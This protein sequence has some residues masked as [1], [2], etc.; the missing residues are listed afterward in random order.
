MDKKELM[1][2]LRSYIEEKILEGM[3]LLLSGW[4]C[5]VATADSLAAVDA[6]LSGAADAPNAIIADYH[7]GDGT[8]IEAIDRVRAAFGP[9]LPG[10]LVTADRSAEVR[11]LADAANIVV[12]NKPVRPASMRAWLTRLA[13]LNKAAA[14]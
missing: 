12:Q 2:A 1:G 11:A 8:G 14:E 10:L 5:E 13:S 4:G 7:L 3:R 9:E 6:L